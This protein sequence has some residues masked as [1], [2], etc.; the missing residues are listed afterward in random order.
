LFK[1]SL[2]NCSKLITVWAA[3]NKFSGC[4]PDSLGDCELLKILDLTNNELSGPVPE[5]FGQLGKIQHLKLADNELDQKLPRT[6]VGCI[7][8]VQC[9][10]RN[11]KFEDLENTVTILSHLM[12][13]RLHIHWN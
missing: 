1:E 9:D 10:L 12:G 6:L 13:A 7:A 8:M 4:I 2:G 11:N 5:T 3:N